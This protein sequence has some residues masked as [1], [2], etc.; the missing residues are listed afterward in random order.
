M[1]F[2]LVA[3]QVPLFHGLSHQLLYK[4]FTGNSTTT[5]MIN[6]NIHALVTQDLSPEPYLDVTIPQ[7]YL[8]RLTL[9]LVSPIDA[10]RWWSEYMGREGPPLET[11]SFKIG[12]PN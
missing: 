8:R 6:D 10:S 1:V 9:A 2:D 5:K 4:Y 7:P 11:T 3:E 12:S